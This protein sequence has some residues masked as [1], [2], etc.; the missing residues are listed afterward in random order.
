MTVALPSGTTAVGTDLGINAFPTSSFKVTLSTGDTFKI[1]GGSPTGQGGVGFL[2]VGFVST[3]PI[4]SITFDGIPVG[5]YSGGG[6][7][8][9]YDNFSFGY[10]TVPVPEPS[11]LALALGVASLFGVT[12]FWRRA[13]S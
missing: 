9:S 7:I 3:S 10:G 4:T 2:F 8:P 6:Y 13:A 11:T 1:T 5:L 12:S